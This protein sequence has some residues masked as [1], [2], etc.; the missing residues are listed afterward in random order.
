LLIKYDDK[1]DGTISGRDLV[2]CILHIC[3][4]LKEDDV[5]GYV[6]VMLKSRQNI[7]DPTSAHDRFLYTKAVKAEEKVKQMGGI[8]PTEKQRDTRWRVDYTQFIDSLEN[9]KK[10]NPFKQFIARLKLFM[11][12]NHL[13]VNRLMKKLVIDDPYS[14]SSQASTQKIIKDRAVPVR[15]FAKFCRKVDKKKTDEELIGLCSEMDVDND[16]FINIYDLSTCLGNF[17]AETF[18]TKRK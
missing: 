8:K 17:N 16:G 10:L 18:Y 5:K 12:K 3:P 9:V 15:K 13:D 11:K 7:P 2:K 1:Y 4:N 14:T 6:N